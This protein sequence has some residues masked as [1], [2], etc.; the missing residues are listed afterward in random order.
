MLLFLDCFGLCRQ[1]AVEDFH[2]FFAGDGLLLQQVLRQLM[3][4]WQVVRKDLLGAVVTLF[5]NLA[6][7]L[8]DLGRCLLRAGQRGV[9][10]L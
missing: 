10:A 1:R 8:V 9:A 5:D 7:L 3:Q 6:D 4:L 2:K